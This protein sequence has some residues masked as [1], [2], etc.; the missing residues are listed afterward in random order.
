M[1]RHLRL[2]GPPASPFAA[3]RFAAAGRARAAPVGRDGSRRPGGGGGRRRRWRR[4]PSS[5]PSRATELAARFDDRNGTTHQSSLVDR[6]LTAEPLVDYLPLSPTAARLHA[7][8]HAGAHADPRRLWTLRPT[9]P[10]R[11]CSRWRSASSG[12]AICRLR[13]RFGTG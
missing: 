1:E 9:R 13:R 4:W 12:G 5:W 10:W 7:R 3:M 6:L 2:V 11:T 8:L